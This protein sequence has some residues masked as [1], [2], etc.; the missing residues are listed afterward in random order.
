MVDE[1]VVAIS[2]VTA[3]VSLG[4]ITYAMLELRRIINR[5]DADIAMRVHI[6]RDGENEI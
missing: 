2:S 3:G 4:F 6:V 1:I 5:L